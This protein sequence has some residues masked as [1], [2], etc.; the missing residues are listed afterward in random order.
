[1][2]LTLSIILLMTFFKITGWILGI[3]GKAIGIVF[4]IVGYLLI[5]VFAVVGLG[6]ALAIIPVIFI[7][8]LISIGFFIGKSVNVNRNN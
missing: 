4:S 6:L 8:G 3:C 5:A 1:M 7:V 2:G